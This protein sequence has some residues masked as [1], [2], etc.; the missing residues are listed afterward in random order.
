MKKEIHAVWKQFEEN[1][2]THSAT[3]YLLAIHDLLETNGY[4]RMIDVSKK[5]EI[6]PG[7]CSVWL[8]NLLKKWLIEEDDNKF[9]RLSKNSQKIVTDTLYARKVLIKY[10]IKTLWVD[11]EMAVIN[12]CKIE[13]LLDISII[14]KIEWTLK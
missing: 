2:L 5:L 11:E 8:K 12:A 9:I 14:K 1:E 10:F 4:A 6:T 3:H 13:H 7:S